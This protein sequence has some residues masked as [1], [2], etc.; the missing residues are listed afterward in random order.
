MLAAWEGLGYYS[1]ARNLHRAAQIVMSE[2]GGQLPG[3]CHALQRLPGIGRYTAGAIASM[4]FG[5]PPPWM[6]ISAGCWPPV[7]PDPAARSPQGEAQLWAWAGEYLPPGR[8]GDFNQALMDLGSML[9][10]PRTPACADCPLQALC[11]AYALGVQEQRPV[12]APKRPRRITP[13]PRR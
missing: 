3:D 10:T 5:L 4:A 8:A 7:Q 1:R 12:L 2:H 11:Q 6:A 9:C 13:S